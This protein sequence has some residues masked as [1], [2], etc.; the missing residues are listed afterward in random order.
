MSD[1]PTRPPGI[2]GRPRP[3]GAAPAAKA[4]RP[5]GARPV[6]AAPPPSGPGMRGVL[7]KAIILTCLILAG[8]IGWKVWVITHPPKNEKI[9]VKTEAEAAIDKG[10]GAGTDILKIQTKVWAKS[11]ELKPEDLSAIKDKLVELREA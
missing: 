11:E 5:A 10:K 1:Q 3:A 6:P 8:A 2:P 4:P 9:D 7:M